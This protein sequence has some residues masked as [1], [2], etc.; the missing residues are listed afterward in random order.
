M[1]WIGAAIGA[2]IIAIDEVQKK[3]GARFRVPVLGAAVGIYL[4]LE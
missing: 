4:P 1:I 2:V 3:R